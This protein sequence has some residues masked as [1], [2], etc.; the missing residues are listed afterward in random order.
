MGKVTFADRSGILESRDEDGHVHITVPVRM[1]QRGGRK[2]L[3]VPDRFEDDAGHCPENRALVAAL[4]RAHAWT[5]L[6]ETGAFGGIEELAIRLKMDVCYVR[7]IMKLAN[8]A[9]DIVEAILD[10]NEPEDFT[11]KTLRKGV[12]LLWEDQ[13][14]QFGFPAPDWG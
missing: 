1:K 10:G 7:R 3:V 8:L 2:E 14:R 13:R 12:P 11:V 5:R 4:V 6:V 9:P